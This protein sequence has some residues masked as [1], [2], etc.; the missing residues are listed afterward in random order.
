MRYRTLLLLV[1]LAL[2]LVAVLGACG[3]GGKY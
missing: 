3:G 1:V 2:C